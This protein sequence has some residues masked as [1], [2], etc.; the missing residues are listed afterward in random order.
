MATTSKSTRSTPS[1]TWSPGAQRKALTV[2]RFG[3]LM[4]CS[5]FIA[6]STSSGA[7][8]STAAPGLGDQRD[9]LAR[10]RRLQAAFDIVARAAGAAACSPATSGQARPSKNTWRRSALTTTVASTRRSPSCACSWPLGPA[11]PRTKT[12]RPPTPSCM[13]A[14]AP[15]A[16]TPPAAASP[17]AA[18]GARGAAVEPPAVERAPGRIAVGRARRGRAPAARA[19]VRPARPAARPRRAPPP[20]RGNRLACSRS[21]SAVSR[22]ALANDGTPTSRD[23]N[24][25][26]LATPTMRYCASAWR[27]RASA[28]GAVAVPDD[29]LGDHRVVVRRDRVALL[30]RRCRRAHARF[31]AAA[32]GAAAVPVEGRKPLSGSSA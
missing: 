9:H 21:I 10:H 25:T 7:P 13:S 4:V 19:A 29:Q 32:T 16:P 15:P 22:S 2:P 11:V 1:T 20:W 26:L 12:A 24:S 28:C 17:G 3:A 31:P 8:L 23:R 18:D 30:A 14:A 6:S 5:I 27:M